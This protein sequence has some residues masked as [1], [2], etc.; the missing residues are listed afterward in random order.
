[1]PP[2]EATMTPEE[3]I[4]ELRRQAAFLTRDVDQAIK[5]LEAAYDGDFDDSYEAEDPHEAA[6]SGAWDELDRQLSYFQ[7]RADKLQA[8]VPPDQDES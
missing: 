7:I 3:I 4:T 5:D 8:G 6:V 2:R 1:V